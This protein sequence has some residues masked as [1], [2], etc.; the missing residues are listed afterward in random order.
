MV[1]EGLEESEASEALEASVDSEDSEDLEDLEG[2]LWALLGLVLV[3]VSAAGCWE[4]F[5]D[6]GSV[7]EVDLVDENVHA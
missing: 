6:P 7:W 4:E 5:L 2:V 3:E 1:S